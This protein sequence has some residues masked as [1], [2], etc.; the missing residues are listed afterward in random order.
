MPTYHIGSHIAQSEKA[1]WR[2]HS[3]TCACACACASSASLAE[4]ARPTSARAAAA[5][6]LRLASSSALRLASASACM[7]KYNLETFF[8]ILIWPPLPPYVDTYVCKFCFFPYAIHSLVPSQS[9]SLYTYICPPLRRGTLPLLPPFLALLARFLQSHRSRERRQKPRRRRTEAQH[10]DGSRVIHRPRACASF[11][12]SREVP[13][14]SEV[15]S[16]EILPRQGHRWHQS[17]R[18]TNRRHI[19]TYIKYIHACTMLHICKHAI[20][21][22]CAYVD[23]SFHRRHAQIRNHTRTE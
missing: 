23:G 3:S 10:R 13:H 20:H 22:M 8:H 17:D 16:L 9:P 7:R 19:Y 6:A 1:R 5:A 4:G 12:V 11:S 15:F 2:S 14:L 21:D 18:W